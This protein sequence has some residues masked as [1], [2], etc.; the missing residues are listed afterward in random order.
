MEARL[1]DAVWASE[2]EDEWSDPKR[3]DP[4]DEA[5]ADDVFATYYGE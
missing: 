4:M 5:A 2:M 1:A 3:D